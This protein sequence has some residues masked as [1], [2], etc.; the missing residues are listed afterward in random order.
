MAFRAGQSR[1]D[2]LSELIADVFLSY[3]GNPDL[4]GRQ[5]LME[6]DADCLRMHIALDA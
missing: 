3:T 5:N 6:R 1:A 4:N 2:L